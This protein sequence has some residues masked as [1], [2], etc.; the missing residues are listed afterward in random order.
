MLD[1]AIIGGGPAAL[2]ASINCK[3][4]NKSVC[5]IG[6]SLDN[7]L[8]YVA[9]KVDNYLG[10]P[11]MSGEEM[12][13]KFY[14]HANEKGVEFKEAKVTQI[15]DMGTHFVL[16]AENNF[17]DAKTIILATG[18]NKSRGILGEA[19]YLGKGVSYC[20]TCDGMLYRGK[21]V[22]VISENPEGEEEANF[23]SDIC[24]SVEYLPLYKD[25]KYTNDKVTIRNEKPTS[26]VGENGKVSAVE[27]KEGSVISTDGV[28]FVKNSMPLDSL[29]SGLKVSG[30]N[31]IV[32]NKMQ[33]SVERVFAAGDCTGMPYQIAVAVGEGVTAALSAASYI[34]KMK[35]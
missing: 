21:K 14:S 16:N 23:L 19:E 17:I 11:N 31:I 32:D 3:Q 4:R 35:K 15:L 7:S 8:L 26:V 9:E 6:R 10:L 34:D 25:V 24:S 22:L 18:I 5:V 28:F 13:N 20:A 29:I 30:N 2:S 12:L 1:V 33:T 27:T